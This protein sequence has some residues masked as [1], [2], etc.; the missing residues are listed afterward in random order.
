MPL[1]D[2][3]FERALLASAKVDESPAATSPEMTA[4]AW[5]RFSARAAAFGAAL[6]GRVPRS[7]DATGA[8]QA[9]TARAAG[10]GWRWLVVA[11]LGGGA[12]TGAAFLLRAPQ[13][14][15]PLG[16]VTSSAADARSRVAGAVAGDAPP[17]LPASRSEARPPLRHDRRRNAQPDRALAEPAEAA[18][19]QT[20][21]A[22][23][24]AALDAARAA[25]AG[26]RFD[27]ALKL[28]SLYHYDFP[29]GELAADAEVI[30]IEALRAE[31]DL[32]EMRRRASRFVQQHPD[33]PHTQRIKRLLVTEPSP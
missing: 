28:I 2:R 8:A 9:T 1:S 18:P 24:V 22:A 16:S 17:V 3:E 20:T 30:A 7:D 13:P 12:V 26:H 6:H 25:A 15:A 4:Q 14:A 29:E 21:L 10:V 31:H 27:E 11:A 23:E 33:D 19:P 32:P 5:A